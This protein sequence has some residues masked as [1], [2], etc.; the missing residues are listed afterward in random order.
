LQQI[1]NSANSFEFSSSTWNASLNDSQI[2]LL[3]R[4]STVYSAPFEENEYDCVLI[5][6]DEVT[7]TFVG[8]PDLGPAPGPE[9]IQYGL[10]LGNEY[11]RRS[12][13][14]PILRPNEERHMDLSRCLA[15]RVTTEALQRSKEIN[16][17]FRET[18]YTL[19]SL[20]KVYSLS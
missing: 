1:A 3:V 16:Q 17:R 13:F 18:V 11:G 14:S 10:V 5:E 12:L 19:L 15:R 4:E 7:T 6:R 2:G 8:T 20:L 9:G